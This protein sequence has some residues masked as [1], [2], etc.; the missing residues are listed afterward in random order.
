MSVYK[1]VN[2]GIS[3][4]EYIYEC[5]RPHTSAACLRGIVHVHT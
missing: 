3:V 1:C 2:V 5:V 4:C